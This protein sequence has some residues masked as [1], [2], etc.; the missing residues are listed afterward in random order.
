LAGIVLLAIIA[1]IIRCVCVN[2]E[3]GPTTSYD[4][5]HTPG[6]NAYGNTGYTNTGYQPTPAAPAQYGYVNQGQPTQGFFAPQV[7]QTTFV[8][9]T[10]TV[11]FR[12]QGAYGVNTGANIPGGYVQMG[13]VGGFG[14]R[15]SAGQQYG[16][17]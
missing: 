10:Q 9:Q 7:Q 2:R 11:G 14:G 12:P 17:R 5:N 13:Q 15:P 3:D 4:Y 6:N 1:G 8:P 16:F